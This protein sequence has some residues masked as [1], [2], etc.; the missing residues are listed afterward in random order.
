MARSMTGFAARS[1][2]E[3]PLSWSW[4]IR[5]VN[6]RGL[7]LRM[8]MPDGI[9]GLE[10]MARSALAARIARGSVTLSLRLAREGAVRELDRAALDQA[11]DLFSAVAEAA[12]AR[13]VELAPARIGDV[14]SQKGV[15]ETRENAQDAGDETLRGRLL[16]E[17][18]LLLDAFDAMRGAEGAATAATLGEILHAIEGEIDCAAAAAEAREA[19]APGTLRAQLDK[20]MS[21]TDAVD[22][23]RLAQEVALIAVRADVAEEIARLRAHLDAARDLLAAEGPVGRKLDFL[24]QELNREANTLCSKSG[25]LDL[26]RAGLEMKALID[27]MREQ[28]QNLE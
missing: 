18:S 15:L 5:A 10:A 4:D 25:D 3:G 20:V 7:D 26:T 27:R 28:V 1:G 12:R 13:G 14:V 6:G 24:T 9:A 16:D 11:L 17:L 8:R 21:G 2:V 22:A 19:K 23:A